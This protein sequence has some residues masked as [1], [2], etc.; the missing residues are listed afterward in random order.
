[1][2]EIRKLTLAAMIAAAETAL[3]YLASAVP[4]GKIAL[5]AAAAL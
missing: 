5:T 1:M 4:S 2:S 3:L